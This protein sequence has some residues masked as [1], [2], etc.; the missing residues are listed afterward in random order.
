[1]QIGDRI[2]VQNIYYAIAHVLDVVWVEEEHRWRIDLDWGIHGTSRVYD[3]DEG[4]IWFRY[5]SVN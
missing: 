5:K 1:M 3:S 4:Q 2:I